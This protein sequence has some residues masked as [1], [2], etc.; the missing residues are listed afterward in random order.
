M[1]TAASLAIALVAAA[2]GFACG[3]KADTAN[4]D[5]VKACTEEAKVCDDG[6]SV[7]RQGPDC[8]FAACPGEGE[9]AADAADEPEEAADG[10]EEPA[11]EASAEEPAE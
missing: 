10:A 1:K 6:S 5:D 4:P 3:P 8:E 9:A 11:D 2:A 7:S